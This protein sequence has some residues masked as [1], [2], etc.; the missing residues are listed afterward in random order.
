MCDDALKFDKLPQTIVETRPPELPPPKYS[1]ISTPNNNKSFRSVA[2]KDLVSEIA[3][4]CDDVDKIDVSFVEKFENSNKKIK[5]SKSR[6]SEIKQSSE[7]KKSINLPPK[8]YKMEESK[9]K[10]RQNSSE[11]KRSTSKSKK[12]ENKEI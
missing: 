3:S 5:R 8:S 1:Q 4:I 12:S 6:E 7:K 11:K 2:L 10:S 9:P